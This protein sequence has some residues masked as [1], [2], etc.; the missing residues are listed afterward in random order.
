VDYLR[1]D[2]I[3]VDSIGHVAKGAAKNGFDSAPEVYEPDFSMLDEMSA[4][5][6]DEAL[7]FPCS[8]FRAKFAAKLISRE[9][10]GKFLNE[11][12]FSD[13]EGREIADIDG[14]GR[15]DLMK[16]FD[17]LDPTIFFPAAKK[18]CGRSDWQVTE[19]QSKH[20]WFVVELSSSRDYVLIESAATFVRAR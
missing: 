16:E 1:L 19:L 5:A 3:I 2:K 17:H 13:V 7:A 11:K 12:G 18:Y 14:D 4:V 10:F 8:A 9:A 20:F 6:S 15:N